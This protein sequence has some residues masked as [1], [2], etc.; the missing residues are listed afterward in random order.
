MDVEAATGLPDVDTAALH[1]ND[2]AKTSCGSERRYPIGAEPTVEGTHFRVWAPR[3]CRVTVV[4]ENVAAEVPLVREPHGYFAAR[5]LGV[6][7]GAKYRFRLDDEPRLF[8]DPASR[9]QPQGPHGPSQVVDPLAFPWTDDAWSGVRRTGQVIYEM[10]VGTFTQEGTWAAAGAKLPQLADLGVTLIEV[11]PVAD[12]GGDF[13]WGYDGV[14]FFAP[15]RLYG[16]PDDFRRFVDR[17]HR[18]GVGVVLDVVYNHFGPDGNYLP[19]FS[20]DYFT[21]RYQTD[22]GQALNY[23]GPNAAP[24]R[25]YMTTNAAYWI[26]EFHLDGLRLDATQNIYDSSP[27]HILAEIGLAARRAAGDR[28]I[29]LVAENEPQ[30]AKLVEP[31]AAGGYGLDAL[32]NDDLHHAA[33]VALTGHAE[34]YY[35]D[36][37]GWPQEFISGLKWGYL[38]QG[39]WYRW[40]KQRRGTPTLGLDRARFVS[41]IENH[42]QV[43]NS[44]RGLRL[45]QLA[46]PGRYRA[47]TA[48]ML[49]APATP[50]LFQGQE[51][52]SSAPFHFFASHHP[53][54][55][56]L[57]FAGRKKF[58][59]QFPSLA[60]PEAQAILVDP[61]APSTFAQSKLD[62]KEW[63]RNAAAVALHRDLL[64]LRRDDPVLSQDEVKL[65]GAVLGDAAF[66]L[67]FFAADDTSSSAVTDRLL[68]VNFGRDLPLSPIPEPLLADPAGL[69][70]QLAWSSDDPC[71]GGTGTT[72]PTCD[73]EWILPGE[74]AL[75]FISGKEASS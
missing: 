3:R 23:D 38:Y 10:H 19:M 28:S 35:S 24:V 18:L 64:H 8:P 55:A 25:E 4:V 41:F 20:A 54:L 71:Y 13:G 52:A 43:A 68:L 9:F 66:A 44:G 31:F 70:W 29:Y 48:L 32:W 22:W 34:A 72:P 26:D 47:M 58:L 17:A 49:L 6:G 46:D 21:D 69:R 60:T 56:K 45:Y 39:Q 50:M 53:D 33:H 42:D 67:R 57:V 11:M 7:I 2:A 15:T 75:F 14:N 51:F 5:A 16:M 37:R 1:S 62:W 61:A 40:Q 59:S 12:F 27:R 63:D 74:S 65:D 30:E 36:Y 73:A